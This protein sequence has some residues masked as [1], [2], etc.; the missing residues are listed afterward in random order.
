[1][2]SVQKLR[3]MRAVLGFWKEVTMGDDKRF[4]LGRNLLPVPDLHI[5]YLGRSL[6]GNADATRGYRTKPKA[7]ISNIGH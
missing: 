1:M 3:I 6:E 2:A 7:P 4:H 5:Y